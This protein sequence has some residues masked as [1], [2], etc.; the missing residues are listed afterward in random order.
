M[1]FSH[2]VNDYVKMWEHLK[3]KEFSK[4]YHSIIDTEIRMYLIPFGFN[5][6]AQYMATYDDVYK[7]EIFIPFL[8]DPLLPK[9][10]PE[11]IKKDI[12]AEEAG[13]YANYWSSIEIQSARNRQIQLYLRDAVR[14]MKVKVCKAEL[15]NKSKPSETNVIYFI[16]RAEIGSHSC[17]TKVYGSCVQVD[18]PEMGKEYADEEL[19]IPI[20]LK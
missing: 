6:L 8:K 12:T 15:I 10:S 13:K 14:F 3:S 4:V 5:T 18:L 19:G 11:A 20:K 16:Y 1:Q 9:L 2:F 17:Y 7:Q